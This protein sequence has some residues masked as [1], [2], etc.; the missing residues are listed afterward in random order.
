MQFLRR[1][2]NKEIMRKL[3]VLS[4]A[5]AAGVMT[6]AA[7]AEVSAA[8]AEKQAAIEAAYPTKPIREKGEEVDAAAV[9][10]AKLAADIGTRTGTAKVAASGG[11][12]AAATAA[13][14]ALKELASK[15]SK[16]EEAAAVLAARK[17]PASRYGTIIQRYASTYG[18][19]V[20][21]AEAVI[22]IESNYRPDA[23]GSA[24]E[25]GLMQIKPATARMMGYSG[26][27][28]DLFHPETNIKF[29]MKYLGKAHRLGGGTICG[30]ILKYNAGH[31]ATRMNPVS[32][33]YC[34]KVKRHL[35]GT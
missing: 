3:T 19:P 26:S 8:L 7:R 18:V 28:D 16:A 12:E 5:I 2:Q 33:D 34:S 32:S 6:S 21:L 35:A 9:K 14:D 15:G 27:T 29:G 13:T 23:L 22:Q 17:S 20:T 10:K 24:G 11:A 4:A 25:V 31:A 1:N 30:T